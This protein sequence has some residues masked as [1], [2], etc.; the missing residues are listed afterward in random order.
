MR[1]VNIRTLRLKK[2]LNYKQFELFEILKKINSQVYKLN[3]FI[4]Y[5]K[6]HFI[7][8]ISLLKSWHSRDNDS[9]SQSILINDKE[10]WEINEIR[11]KKIRNNEFKY[12]INWKDSHFYEDL[13]KLIKH[14]ENVKSVIKDFKKTIKSRKSTF[15]AK[16]KMWLL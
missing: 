3:L 16:Q 14:F 12:L 6:I 9:E 11:D 7:F 2:K 10:K 8:Y 15:K 13:W 1:S 4:K 5:D